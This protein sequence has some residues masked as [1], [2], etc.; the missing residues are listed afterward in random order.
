MDKTEYVL[1][2]VFFRS[3]TG[4]ALQV[5]STFVC[6]Q[7]RQ[8]SRPDLPDR[9]EDWDVFKCTLCHTTFKSAAYEHT[10]SEEMWHECKLFAQK[11]WRIETAYRT[12][13]PRALL[14]TVTYE[15]EP[16]FGPRAPA[17]RMYR[18]ATTRS[19]DETPQ[20]WAVDT[21]KFKAKRSSTSMMA[22]H[23]QGNMHFVLDA[24]RPW[25]DVWLHC[26]LITNTLLVRRYHPLSRQ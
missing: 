22:V 19:D 8:P 21:A 4:H 10:F 25:R 18:S 11:W 13:P 6:V 26:L 15:G 7:L 3:T 9:R 14:R 17:S 24:R 16:P 23:D 1:S 12:F 2:A 20:P 5:L